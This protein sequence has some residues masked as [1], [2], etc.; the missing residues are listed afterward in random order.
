VFDV[1]GRTVMQ[2]TLNLARSGVATLDLRHLSAGVYLV[3]FLAEDFAG[4]QKL[5][6]QR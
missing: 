4:T 5:V 2:K 3:K 6:V 1:T